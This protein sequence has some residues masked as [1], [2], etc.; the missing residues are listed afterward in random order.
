M[1]SLWSFG[2][3]LEKALFT[4]LFIS[5]VAGNLLFT[6]M[7]RELNAET[8]PEGRAWRRWYG[9][10]RFVVWTEYSQRHPTSRIQKVFLLV[11]ALVFAALVGL[12]LTWTGA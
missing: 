3:H 10:S 2:S 9:N 12:G 5:A 6:K 1:M 4:I 8:P 7:L 11:L